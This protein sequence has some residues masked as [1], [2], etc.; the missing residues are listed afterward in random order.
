[1]ESIVV[2]TDCPPFPGNQF[3]G[4]DYFTYGGAF[5]IVWNGATYTG[6]AAFR[7][8]TGQE[9]VGTNLS[10]RSV[11]PLLTNSGGGGT[12]GIPD[13]LETLEAY[14]LLSGFLMVNAGLNLSIL[15]G[16][17]PGDRDFFEN[18]VPPGAT[19]DIESN[20]PAP[21]LLQASP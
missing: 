17:N 16:V 21:N 15:F 11:D 14:K 1:M 3:Q 20:L 6:L 18:P 19:L 13:L 10:G 4:N 12:I 2:W 8:A 7:S 5:S 9:M